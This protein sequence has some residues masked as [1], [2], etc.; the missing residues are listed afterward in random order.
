[1]KTYFQD[2]HTANLNNL[3]KPSCLEITQLM[4]LNVP[5]IT[6]CSLEEFQKANTNNAF[7]VKFIVNEFKTDIIIS[8][9]CQNIEFI[10]S[11]ASIKI[12]NENNEKIEFKGRYPEQSLDKKIFSLIFSLSNKIFNNIEEK[13]E[14]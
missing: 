6:E 13:I 9:A 1:M 2:I 11:C 3:I 4:D 12:K 7:V 10:R 14:C 8:I 5:I